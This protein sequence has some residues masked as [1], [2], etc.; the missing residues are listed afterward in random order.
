LSVA[1]DLQDLVAYLD[2]YLDVGA[3]PDYPEAHNGLQV[4]NSGRVQQLAACTDACQTT[5]DA[6]ARLNADLLIVHHGLYW[7][8]GITPLTGRSYRRVKQLLEHDIAVY[9]SHLPLDAHPE[10]GNNA[11]LARA[12]GLS[13]L[14]PFGEFQGSLIGYRGTLE[15][16]R[17]E[18]SRRLQ[19]LFSAEPFLVAAGPERVARVGVVSGGAGRLIGQAAA[20][21]LDTFITGEG[22]HHTYFDAEELGINVF[23]AGHYAT[24]TLGV[25]ALAAHVA[26]EFELDWEFL[27]HPTGL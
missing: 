20:A 25:K 18:L 12:I 7:G 21:G 24:E 10:V 26:Q 16:G 17:D 6:A 14:E 9:S 11:Q 23:Y 2:R 1:V 3:I 22:S 19:A 15:L 4:A 27:D 8:A 5:I 13:E